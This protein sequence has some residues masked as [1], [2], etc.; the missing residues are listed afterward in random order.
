MSS[1]YKDSFISSFPVCIPFISFSGH[2]A[3]IRTSG[4]N[5]NRSGNS[6]LGHLSNLQRKAIKIYVLLFRIMFDLEEIPL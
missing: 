5:T 3:L 1:V 6:G 4:K 2:S